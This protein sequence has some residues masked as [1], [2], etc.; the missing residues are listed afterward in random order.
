[1]LPVH[2]DELAAE[3]REGNLAAL[4]E[5]ASFDFPHEEVHSPLFERALVIVAALFFDPLSQGRRDA[6]LAAMHEN[7][8]QG[9]LI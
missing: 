5:P 9:H 3:L 7:F 1:V 8:G 4:F 6:H 2:A